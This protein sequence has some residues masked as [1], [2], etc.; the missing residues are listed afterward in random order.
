MKMGL[1]GLKVC[2]G[3]NNDLRK[4]L[5]NENVERIGCRKYLLPFCPERVLSVAL[6][7]YVTWSFALGKT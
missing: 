7:G 3:L 1:N 6:Y 2:L 5:N 4:A